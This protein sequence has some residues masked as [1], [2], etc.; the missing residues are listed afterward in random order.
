[1]NQPRF[2]A[3]SGL[4]SYILTSILIPGMESY[5]FRHPIL[6]FQAKQRIDLNSRQVL[7]VKNALK[8]NVW[9]SFRS[10]LVVFR[11]S[12]TFQAGET[13]TWSPEFRNADGSWCPLGVL[14][15]L[16]RAIRAP[17]RAWGRSC[18]TSQKVPP[19]KCDPGDVWDP[20]ICIWWFDF[21]NGQPMEGRYG[22]ANY[23]NYE[24]Y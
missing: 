3:S 21:I 16:S 9:I 17:W 14:R 1:M 6:I 20:E 23:S 7:V 10:S 11:A 24:G 4:T 18:S 15:C 13:V 2:G 22:M 12:E 19:K 8:G 5:W